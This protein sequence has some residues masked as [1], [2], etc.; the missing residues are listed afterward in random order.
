VTP[1]ALLLVLTAAAANAFWHMLASAST[2]KLAFAGAM[3]LVGALLLTPP[4][5]YFWLVAAPEPGALPMLLVTI[6]LNLSYHIWLAATY[7]RAD[8]SVGYPV[9]RGSAVLLVAVIGVAF[10]GERVPPLALAAMALVPVGMFIAYSRGGTGKRWTLPLAAPP[11]VLVA[12]VMTGIIVALATL[13]D[14]LAVSHFEPVIYQHIAMVGICTGLMPFVVLRRKA[15]LLPLLRAEWKPIVA[16]GSLNSLAYLLILYAL[17][18]S[19]VTYVAAAREV[20]VVFAALFGALLLREPQGTRRVL[21]AVIIFLGVV[22][23]AS[24][25]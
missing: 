11:G 4:A 2:D 7:R 23:M 17:T 9:M 5:V 21:G 6:L 13:W 22:V 10:M 20:S 16:S 25:R 14:K 12:P 1:T 8:L 3:S 18:V 24:V 15:A 19:P